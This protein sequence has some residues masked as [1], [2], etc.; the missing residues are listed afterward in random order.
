MGVRMLQSVDGA[1]VFVL[2]S[3]RVFAILLCSEFRIRLALYGSP[4]AAE[5]AV[6]WGEGERLRHRGQRAPVARGTHAARAYRPIGTP[7]SSGRR[8]A[9]AHTLNAF[10]LLWNLT[11]QRGQV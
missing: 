4:G 3:S 7:G 10:F 8:G 11:S 9:R 6:A 5:A 2:I 1:L